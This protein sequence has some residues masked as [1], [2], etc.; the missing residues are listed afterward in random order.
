MGNVFSCAIPPLRHCSRNYDTLQSAS[1]ID[2]VQDT[3]VGTVVEPMSLG[4]SFTVQDLPGATNTG[5]IR[6]LSPLGF[7]ASCC[8]L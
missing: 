4:V 5:L 8:P 1:Q 3:G 2:G 6:N 7:P